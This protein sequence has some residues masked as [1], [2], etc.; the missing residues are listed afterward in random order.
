MNLQNPEFDP[1]FWRSGMETV[2]QENDIIKK[3]LNIL[4]NTI[5]DLYAK[6]DSAEKSSKKNWVPQI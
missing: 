5:T 3:E 6:L 4:K 2:H 1:Y